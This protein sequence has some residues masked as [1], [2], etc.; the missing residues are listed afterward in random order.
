MT[1]ML[2]VCKGE[3]DEDLI[4]A[5]HCLTIQIFAATQSSCVLPILPL[6]ACL[7]IS[8]VI[9]SRILVSCRSSCSSPL[10]GPSGVATVMLVGCAQ[11]FVGKRSLP[12]RSHF[13]PVLSAQPLDLLPSFHPLFSLQSLFSSVVITSDSVHIWSQLGLVRCQQER[14]KVVCFRYVKSTFTHCLV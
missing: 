4:F 12:T 10:C 11:N 6:W 3:V 14:L 13:S 7:F 9:L 5:S 8:T 1:Q 2:S